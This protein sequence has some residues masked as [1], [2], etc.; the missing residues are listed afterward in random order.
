[1]KSIDP[2][3]AIDA[4]SEHYRGSRGARYFARQ[5]QNGHIKGRIEARKFRSYVKGGDVVLDFGCG[6]GY[7]LSS[8]N[9]ARRLGVEVNPAARAEAV[10]HGIECYESLLEI[11]DNCIDVAISNHALEHVIHPIAIL[12]EFRRKLKEDGTL[13]LCLPI[14]DWRVERHFDPSD[15]NHHL[16]TWTPLLLG[17]S[18]CEAGFHAEK[19]SVSVLTHAWFPGTA[20]VFDRMPK[21]LFDL[22]CVFYSIVVKRRQ[23]FA[24]VRA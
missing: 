23:L 6:G 11:P 14:D 1:M 22:L 19:F 16:H 18:L 21:R 20:R 15:M 5:S 24:V 9:C 17:N 12:K 4:S 13:I 8:L 10:K 3:V 7:V 2:T